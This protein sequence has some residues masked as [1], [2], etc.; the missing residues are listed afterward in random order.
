MQDPDTG[1]QL[2]VPSEPDDTSV[3]ILV[4]RRL[5]LAEWRSMHFPRHHPRLSLLRVTATVLPQRLRV[6]TVRLGVAALATV[7]NVD[8]LACLDPEMRTSR[9]HGEALC[10]AHVRLIADRPVDGVEQET[11]RP[12]GSEG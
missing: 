3:D 2:R 6:E 9:L 7:A 1:V 8:Y 11:G 10:H 5:W 12:T 4:D